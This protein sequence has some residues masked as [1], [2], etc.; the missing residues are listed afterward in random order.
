[1][2]KFLFLL[3]SLFVLTIMS[4]RDKKGLPSD[5]L[6]PDRMRD[7]LWDMIS[8]SQYLSLYVLPKDSVDKLAASAQVYGRV[9]QIYKISK[10]QFDK[11]YSYY[12][13]HDVLLKPI[14]DS[15][16]KRQAYSV[17]KLQKP[18]DTLRNA[19]PFFR[20]K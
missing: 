17:E 2:R 3:F 18:D 9:F 11:S 6:P 5:I 19:K 15:L 16:S 1:M 12:R 13:Q 7:V 10:E 8:A 14:L 20:E 4:C